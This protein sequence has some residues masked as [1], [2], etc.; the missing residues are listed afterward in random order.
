MRFTLQKN[1]VKDFAAHAFQ[2]KNLNK[3]R[4]YDDRVHSILYSTVG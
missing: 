4:V 1:T 3:Q 2:N